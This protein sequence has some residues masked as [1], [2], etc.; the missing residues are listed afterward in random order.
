MNSTMSAIY[1][2]LEELKLSIS[3]HKNYLSDSSIIKIEFDIQELINY[4][5]K[6]YNNT[7]PENKIKNYIKVNSNYP[8]CKCSFLIKDKRELMEICFV[9]GECY[10]Y[11]EYIIERTNT[12]I[13]FIKIK[14]K[15]I[16]GLCDD[17]YTS[18][19]TINN[20]HIILTLEELVN[21]LNEY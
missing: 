21:N 4:I 1:N 9:K 2:K 19:S 3:L 14:D 11:V 7:H 10:Y 5:D 13:K 20:Y 15:I 18:E 6:K 8:N 16:N 12:H 17:W